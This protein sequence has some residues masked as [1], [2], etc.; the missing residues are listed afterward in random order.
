MLC[1]IKVEIKNMFIHWK[2]R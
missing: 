2:L 1:Y